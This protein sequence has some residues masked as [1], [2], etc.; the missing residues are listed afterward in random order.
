MELQQHEYYIHLF[1]PKDRILTFIWTKRTAAM[2]DED[3]KNGLV[4]YAKFAEVHKPLGLL[5]NGTEFHFR[6]SEGLGDW[7]AK[8]IIPRYNRGGVKK[9]AFLNENF[10]EL[11]PE[12]RNPGEDFVTRYFNSERAAY[13]WLWE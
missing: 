9:F 4:A 6:P 11:P 2:T 5:I 13:E 1:D 10:S 3:F 12:E 8:E 7:R